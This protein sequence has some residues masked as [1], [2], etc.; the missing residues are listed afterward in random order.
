MKMEDKNKEE[1]ARKQTSSWI[2][3]DARADPG[4]PKVNQDQSGPIWWDHEVWRFQVPVQHTRPAIVQ[5]VDTYGCLMCK[6]V[7]ED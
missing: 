6:P 7:S 3:W 4:H 5:H 1:E 2:I